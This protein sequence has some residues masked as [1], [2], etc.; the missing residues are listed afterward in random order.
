MSKIEKAL[1]A[2]EQVLEGIED[3]TLSTSSALLKCLKIARLLNDIESLTWLQYE[4]SGYP[5]DKNG[6]IINKAWNVGNNHGRGFI[7]NGESVIFIELASELEADIVSSKNAITNFTTNGASVSG[8]KAYVA[9]N[10]LTSS[11]SGSTK[12]LMKKIS[13]A[14]NHLAILRGKYYEY[15][16]EKNIELLFGNTA[17]SIF[18][19]YRQ[20]V[21]NGFSELSHQTILKLQAI[22]DKINSDNPE[23][24]S[25]A[26]TTCRRLFENTAIELFNKYFPNFEGKL[27]KTR[28]G[29]EIDVSGDHFRNKIS[30]VIE[31]L[32]EKSTKKTLVGSSILYTIDW[33][34]NLSNLQNKGVHAEITKD[35]AVKC[36]IHTYICLGDILSLESK[37]N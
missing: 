28:S 33:I 8:E 32:Q 20:S 1:E 27:Y 17:E 25:Q 4:Y 12:G 31:I 11:V 6:N 35:D 16:L 2:T 14:E 15:A 23:L 30:A 9:M 37:N 22:E 24:Y 3:Q 5:K 19:T 21:E 29:K 26:L 36:I 34:E 10:A 18:G 7:D 13:T